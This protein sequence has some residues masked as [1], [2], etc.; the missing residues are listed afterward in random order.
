MPKMKTHKGLKDR[1]KVTGRG[2][3]LRRKAGSSHL[4]SVKNGKR[5]RGFRKDAAVAPA[6]AR[7]AKAMMGE[8]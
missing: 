7:K 1:Y 3:V 6:F 5:R 2:K 4:M 8:G